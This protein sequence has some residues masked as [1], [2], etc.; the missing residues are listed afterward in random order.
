MEGLKWSEEREGRRVG[1]MVT[2]VGSSGGRDKW[3]KGSGGNRV[4]VSDRE[5]RRKGILCT[6][7]FNPYRA[8]MYMIIGTALPHHLCNYSRYMK[9]LINHHK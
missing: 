9:R 3:R 7:P 6:E 2:G 4:G 1:G 8:A 5:L